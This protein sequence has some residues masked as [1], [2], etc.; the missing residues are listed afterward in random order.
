MSPP[1]PV[2]PWVQWSNKLAREMYI[3]RAL[4][5]LQ[6]QYPDDSW[7]VCTG[8]WRPTVIVFTT[9]TASHCCTDGSDPSIVRITVIVSVATIV[10]P[11]T[12]T[13]SRSLL[14]RL[15]LIGGPSTSIV[16]VQ[17]CPYVP[18]SINRAWGR[19]V[20]PQLDPLVRSLIQGSSR[21]V[22]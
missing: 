3:K 6:L 5:W 12:H 22:L 20:S 10:S 8:P 15:W 16:T 1:S 4:S 18:R 7:V 9:R 2:P 17:Y 14:L 19:L 21:L 11:L 13:D